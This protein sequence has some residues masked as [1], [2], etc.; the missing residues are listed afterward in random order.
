MTC[1]VVPVLVICHLKFYSLNLETWLT[2]V[3]ALVIFWAQ[4]LK[5]VPRMNFASSGYKSV[6]P[7][8]PKLID[9]RFA[10][11]R[12]PIITGQL[13]GPRMPHHDELP[14]HLIG[15]SDAM[16]T[17]KDW[18][19]A[20]ET[21]YPLCLLLGDYGT[22]KTITCQKLV[23]DLQ[24]SQ[25]HDAASRPVLYFDLRNLNTT[26]ANTGAAQQVNNAMVV[27][28]ANDWMVNGQT[29]EAQDIHTWINRGALVVFDGLDDFLAHCTPRNGTLFT[30][31]LRSLVLNSSASP[32]DYTLRPQVLISS[33]RQCFP[34]LDA[35]SGHF[36]DG[37]D[38]F[39]DHIKVVELRYFSP[40][41]VTDYLSGE[42][43]RLGSP[44]ADSNEAISLLTSQKD[45]LR[46][47]QRPYI[48]SWLPQVLLDMASDLKL[49]RQF[50][51]VDVYEKLANAWLNH[52]YVM[53]VNY[54]VNNEQSSISVS[55]KLSLLPEVAGAMQRYC[56]NMLSRAQL[57]QVM[58]D[59]YK[60][61][62]SCHSSQDEVLESQLNEVRNATMLTHMVNDTFRFSHTSQFE[63]F[64]AVYLF[65]ALREN[66]P[67]RWHVSTPSA[68]TLE[69][70]GQLIAESQ[71]PRSPIKLP[72]HEP[73]VIETL[74]HWV[75]RPDAETNT[76][77]LNYVLHQLDQANDPD[78][79]PDLTGIRLEGAHLNDLHIRADWH[80]NLSGADFSNAVMPQSILDNC[81][82][83]R[84]A[85]V[86]AAMPESCILNSMLVDTK[87]DQ[88]TLRDVTFR[89]C[90][91]T[92]SS[93]SS[94]DSLRLS[95]IR[96]VGTPPILADLAGTTVTPLTPSTPPDGARLVLSGI[97]P[98][99]VLSVAW[100]PD[101]KYVASGAGDHLL[102]LWQADTGRPVGEPFKGHTGAVRSIAWSPDG[103]HLVS[104]G[105]DGTVRVWDTWTHDEVACWNHDVKSVRTVAWSPDGKRLV[106]GGDDGKIR[107][108]SQTSPGPLA[109]QNSQYKIVRSVAWS[110]NG[111]LVSVGDDGAIHVWDPDTL[112]ERTPYHA[113]HI[114]KLRSVAW[115]PD[116]K[117]LVFGGN[118]RKVSVLDVRRGKIIAAM[119][120]HSDSVWSVAWTSDGSHV[121]SCADDHTVRFW[122]MATGESRLLSG[123]TDAV[124][125]VACSPTDPTSIVS[126]SDDSTVRVWNAETGIATT[127]ISG[128]T[129]AAWSVTWSA[130][131]QT[132]TSGTG[133]HTVRVWSRDTGR[134]I[135]TLDGHTSSV[136]AVAWSPVKGSPLLASTGDETICLWDFSTKQPTVDAL[137][138]HKGPVW[139][140]A[141]NPDGKCLASGGDDGQ[142]LVWDTN[143][144][145]SYATEG[146]KGAIRSVAWSPDGMHLASAGDDGQ[147]RVWKKAAPLKP[148]AKWSCNDDLIAIRSVAWSPDSSCLVSGGNDHVVHLWLNPYKGRSNEIKLAG[149]TDSVRSVGWS[150]NG[151]RIVSGSDDSTVRVWDVKK[152]SQSM[153]MR[154]HTGSVWSV[155]WSPDGSVI[156]SGGGDGIIYLWDP[157]T[158]EDIRRL[159]RLPDFPTADTHNA[160]T[161]GAENA[162]IW[163]SAEAWR[164]L[165][166][167]LPTSE[168]RPA[169]KLPAEFFT[170]PLWQPRSSNQE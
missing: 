86:G 137:I 148:V 76:I 15:D 72:E 95:V 40:T 127:I 168:A 30:D 67:E 54:G 7:P 53:G 129:S 101:G 65:K 18:A 78:T 14:T 93:F 98:G 38:A 111:G 71:D 5:L 29:I 8:L 153:I 109:V 23:R 48:L 68:L 66:K 106:S 165:E 6:N 157:E 44:E 113:D 55:D 99:L 9:L 139:S 41:V 24:S 43:A 28:A 92:G 166:W 169:Q 138:G 156:A 57:D 73:R 10:E 140:L 81:D 110:T 27:C 42:L 142:I 161:W 107:I 134:N 69:F 25:P 84:A 136:R 118:D 21:Q 122:D 141:W 83:S 150:P 3:L 59:W 158:R 144:K 145:S 128:C 17:L 33:R 47:A 100:S 22:G 32:S 102:R 103:K 155:A 149:H 26:D 146:H 162:L 123:H 50:R 13:G 63:Y 58:R 96:C 39:E 20:R 46:I 135:A 164:F 51:V 160:V 112:D 11:E 80:L 36:T 170:S 4:E 12:H 104:G 52:E 125:S 131:G 132:L 121:V 97:D 70:L 126:G 152:C 167:V 64:L 35:M 124:W 88:A 159:V 154:G 19:E 34:T 61:H 143:E 89:M 79:V 31:S 49:G 119:Q 77:I 114:H 117:Y 45:L 133:D 56:T 90:N 115:S 120:G 74:Q 91:M 151:E 116:G 147:I 105:G 37:W 163:A 85:F 75:Q 82:L 108:W 87:F 16:L 60:S 62:A 2:C 130:D 94:V 1:I